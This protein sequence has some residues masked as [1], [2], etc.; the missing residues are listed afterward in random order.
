M[1]AD[2]TGQEEGGEADETEETAAGARNSQRSRCALGASC[3]GSNPYPGRRVWEPCI[4]PEK[5][6]SQMETE[7][8][9]ALYRGSSG[10]MSLKT[11]KNKCLTPSKRCYE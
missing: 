8:S 6:P 5:F 4:T 1:V 7:L 3:L 2:E 9:S 10:L 11:K